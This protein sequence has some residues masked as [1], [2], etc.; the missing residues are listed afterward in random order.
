MI[1]VLANIVTT[2]LFLSIYF[3]VKELLQKISL[4]MKDKKIIR[5]F[6][7]SLKRAFLF[8]G[9]YFQYHLHLKYL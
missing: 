4:G 6:F 9:Q 7:S 1:Q 3:I 8:S 5:L 2:N